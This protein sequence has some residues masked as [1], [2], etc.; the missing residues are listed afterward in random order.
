M[1]HGQPFLFSSYDNDKPA[2]E[3]FKEYEKPTEL[4]FNQCALKGSVTVFDR[5]LRRVVV[6]IW[7]SRMSSE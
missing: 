5:C 6:M 2:R 3:L 1:G 7:R 4:F